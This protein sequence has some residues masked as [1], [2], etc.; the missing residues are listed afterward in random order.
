MTTMLLTIYV[1]MWPVFAAAVLA[2]LS[3]GVLR[4][5]RSAKRN[6]EQLV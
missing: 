2:L 3:W 6:G 4:D 5:M 1:L